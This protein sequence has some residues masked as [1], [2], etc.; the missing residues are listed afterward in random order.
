MSIYRLFDCLLA[1]AKAISTMRL[2]LL[3]AILALLGVAGYAQEVET[4]TGQQKAKE[5]RDAMLAQVSDVPGLPRVLLL[6]DS[7]S[8]MYTVQVRA[9]LR[10]MANVHR[11]A[12]NCFY[13][14]NGVKKIDAWLGSGKW[15]VIHFNFGLHDNNHVDAEGKLTDVAKGK[16]IATPAEYE[17]NMRLIVERLRKTGAVLIFATTTPIPPDSMGRREGAE[18]TYNEVAERVMREGGV[19][20]NDLH[21]VVVEQKLARLAPNNVHFTEASSQKLAEVVAA[22]ITAALAVAK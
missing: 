14:A 11:P 1:A 10:G 21:H 2:P 19:L 20:I 3:V 13:S 5:L 6:G 16:I 4:K 9:Q 22:K 15:E 18:L 8:M 17:Q 12:E 7:I